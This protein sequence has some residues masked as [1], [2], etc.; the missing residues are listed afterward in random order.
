MLLWMLSVFFVPILK[1][2]SMKCWFLCVALSCFFP[3]M[4]FASCTGPAGVT[5]NFTFPSSINLALVPMGGVLAES[6]SGEVSQLFMQCGPGDVVSFVDAGNMELSSYPNVYKTNV[7]GIGVR[8]KLDGWMAPDY[9]VPTEYPVPEKGLNSPW[10]FSIPHAGTL[11]L[12]RIGSGIGN[13][14]LDVNIKIIGKPPGAPQLT[15]NAKISSTVSNNVYMMCALTDSTLNVPMGKFFVGEVK[16]GIASEKLFSFNVQCTGLSASKRPPVKVYF[17]GDS[18]A[19]GSLNLLGAGSM[20]AASGVKI[21]L[22]SS[23]DIKLPFSLGNALKLDWQRSEATREIYGFSGK[24]K[25]VPTGGEIKP[26]VA[27]AVMSIVLD[28][29]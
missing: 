29:N 8:L 16:S 27:N 26:G 7:E 14:K 20:N 18:P 11:Q 17:L 21:S 22:V 24:A 6:K 1:V 15:Y 2:K 12:V 4:A 25:Y 9:Y 23:K 13:N 28:Y 3:Q 19:D 5:Y 10:I